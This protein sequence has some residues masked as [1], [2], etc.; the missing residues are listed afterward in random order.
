MYSMLQ[1]MISDVPSCGGWKYAAAHAIATMAYPASSKTIVDGNQ[2]GLSTEELIHGLKE[3][4]QADY[5]L[6]AGYLK[7]P[8]LGLHAPMDLIPVLWAWSSV[9]QGWEGGLSRLPP[10]MRS[11]G[12]IGASL[13]GGG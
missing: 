4:H 2:T 12:P 8:R 6:L 1:V 13:R 5:V 3:Q 9:R 11:H 10:L 7:V